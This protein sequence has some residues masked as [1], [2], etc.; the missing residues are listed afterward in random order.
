MSLDTLR[1][2]WTLGKTQFILRIAGRYL[3]IVWYLLEPLAYFLLF[4]LLQAN[5]HT[6]TVA[7]YPSYLLLGL[8]MINFFMAATSGALRSIRDNSNLIKSINLPLEVFPVS[9]VIQFCFSHSFELALFVIIAAFYH[10]LSWGVLLYPV[11]FLPFA[12]FAIG[13]ALIVT[14]IGVFIEDFINV[15][16][17]VA[18]LIWLATP[19]FYVA[20]PG[21]LAHYLNLLNPLSYF[22]N[23][24]RQ[25][26]IY[27]TTPSSLSVAI[28]LA[29]AA[30]SL[31]IGLIAFKTFKKSFGEYL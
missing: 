31:A 13:I 16:S 4:L 27:G 12:A 28:A 3:G 14:T 11:I 18:R 23:I 15:W 6:G 30:A 10:E 20:A 17:M 1:L 25:I 7:N 22:L 24:A 21:T 5:L 8:I 2:A 26:I 9:A 29:S 19:V